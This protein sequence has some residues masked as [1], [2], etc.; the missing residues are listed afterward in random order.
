MRKKNKALSLLTFLL[1]TLPTL[2][3]GQAFSVMTYN[4]RFDNPQ[5]GENR[6]DNRKDDL[7]AQ[8]RSHD[9]DILGIQE[10]LLHQVAF[11]EKGLPAH[12]RIGLGRED[13]AD[14][15]EFAAV[16]IRN[17]RFE[18]LDKGTFWLSETPEKVSVGWDAALERVCTWTH[19]QD[20]LTGKELW[21]YNAHFDHR[22]EQARLKSARLILKKIEEHT[23]GADQ[24]IIVMG[25]LNAVPDSPVLKTLL[26]PLEDTHARAPRSSG[27]EGT[28]N[29]FDPNAEVGRRIDYVLFSPQLSSEEYAVPAPIVD[30]R[31]LSDHFPVKAQLNW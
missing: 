5:D 2:L 27:P 19:L 31:Y 24:A 20:K 3:D 18:I 10:G 28:W 11:L 26:T 6:W 30:G 21:V 9:P 8:I 23:A 12:T 25:D 22:G 29:G 15:G 7:L 4:I 13:G 16:Y 14:K 17:D 1:L